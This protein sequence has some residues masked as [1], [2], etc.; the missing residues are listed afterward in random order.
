M[1][2]NIRELE[3][4]KN[5]QLTEKNKISTGYKLHEAVDLSQSVEDINRYLLRYIKTPVSTSKGI[6]KIADI[7]VFGSEYED[8]DYDDED[9]DDE[10]EDGL[11]EENMS[12]LAQYL[13]VKFWNHDFES[14]CLYDDVVTEQSLSKLLGINVSFSEAGRQDDLFYD[15]DIS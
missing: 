12:E 6:F 13:H 1:R 14:Q 15:F 10:D 5:A 4:I 8:E 7:Y 3:I 11:N 9:Y 2:Y